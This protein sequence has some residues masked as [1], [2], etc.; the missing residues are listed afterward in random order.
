MHLVQLRGVPLLRPA[1]AACCTL[2]LAASTTTARAARIAD[3]FV[4][5]A[6]GV[7]TASVQSTAQSRLPTSAAA[8]SPGT[9]AESTAASQSVHRPGRHV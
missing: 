1:A 8:C 3:A 6:A 9:A 5:P 7:A 4:S 2:A